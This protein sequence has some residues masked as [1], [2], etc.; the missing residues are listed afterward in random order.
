MPDHDVLKS[1]EGQEPAG[2]NPQQKL[3]IARIG[4]GAGLLHAAIL[5][6]TEIQQS[7]KER[8]LQALAALR[9]REKDW[10]SP[11]DYPL[12][13]LQYH[14]ETHEFPAGQRTFLMRKDVQHST[15]MLA[16]VMGRSDL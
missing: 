7:P 6:R 13:P 12:E 11:H 5:A 1:E 15:G 8:K 14:R 16:V 9:E 4:K 3:A 10:L 2:I